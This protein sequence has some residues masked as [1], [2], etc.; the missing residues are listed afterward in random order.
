VIAACCY[1][2]AKAEESPMHIKTVVQEAKTVFS[3]EQRNFI[4]F[5]FPFTNWIEEPYNIKNFP[6]DNTKL[7][8]ME[9]YLVDDLEC[10]LTVF[11]P[12]RSLL[13]LCKKAS[14]NT[15]P[16]PTSGSDINPALMEAEAGELQFGVGG[17]LLSADDL[18]VGLDAED[19]PRYWGTG[20]GRLELSEN[21][22]QTAWYV[23]SGLT[24]TQSAQLTCFS[25]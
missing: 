24:W 10:D 7:A 4:F 19:G 1:V 17:D 6:S 23:C 16:G 21:A 5:I 8:E 22:V 12:Y 25:I 14:P 15:S 9:F 18:G 20:E 3:R 13:A 2:A 11:H